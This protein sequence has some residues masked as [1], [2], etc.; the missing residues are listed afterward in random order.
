MKALR[1]LLIYIFITT[2]ST[3][4]HCQKF[5]YGFKTGVVISNIDMTNMVTH[6][7]NPD[8]PLIWFHYFTPK[9]GI[10]IS[11][12]LGYNISSK[13][14]IGI[15]PGYILKGANF[16]DS[17][18]KLDLHYLNFPIAVQYK[19]G[20]KTSFYLG[21]EF[22]HLLNAKL[23]FDGSEID[24]K[25]FYDEKT[26]TSII[27]G[28]NYFFSKSFCLGLR[29]N[30]GLTKISETVWTDEI[31]DLIGRVNEYN[32]YTLLYMKFI[33]NDLKPK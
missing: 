28:A 22:S 15:E 12:N 10:N 5:E 32:Y 33:L 14:Q 18:S 9:T 1:L 20:E 30:Y 26:E 19:P 11:L 4:A 7:V 21:P 3:E 24:M 29:L 13:I 23:E 31:G 2:F 25:S 27:F 17:D 6:H 8:K 16:S